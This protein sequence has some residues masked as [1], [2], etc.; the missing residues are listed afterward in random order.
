MSI[1]GAIAGGVA[2]LIGNRQKGQINS[3][4]AKDQRSWEEQISSTAY[5]RAMNDMK[6]AG[7][8]PILAYKMGGATTP[9][10]AA[11]TISGESVAGGMAAGVSA[12]KAKHEISNLKQTNINID[13]DT[14]KKD[15]EAL[16]ASASA[17]EILEREKLNRALENQAREAAEKAREERRAI[18]FDNE[19]RKAEAELF[20]TEMGAKLR[21]LGIIRDNIGGLIPLTSGGSSARSRR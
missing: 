18:K 11:G 12:A 9:T 21:A 7:L 17:R 16:A 20:K 10:G 5:R 8:N 14:N 13:A 3:L 2:S 19:K 1:W 6:L 15:Q 4:A